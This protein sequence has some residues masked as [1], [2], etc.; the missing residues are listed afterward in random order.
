M[1]VEQPKKKFPAWA[2]A[3][4]VVCVLFFGGLF[5]LRM[6]LHYLFS[7]KSGEYLTQ[8]AAEKTL[9]KM[10]E[11]AGDGK[12]K[13]EV[14][15]GEGGQGI[16]IKSKEGGS[17][18]FAF[19]AGDKMPG[20]FPS[21]I[22][23]FNPAEFKGHV[24]VMGM[25]SLEWESQRPMQEVAQFY[26]NKMVSNGWQSTLNNSGAEGYAGGFKKGDRQVMVK[27]SGEEGRSD[28]NLMYGQIPR[29]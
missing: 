12:E 10:L 1:E 9:E 24:M 25:H 22:A 4:I 15:L 7:T 14:N 11:Q 3:L 21:D 6:G 26:Q 29:N 28:I 13:V 23:I 8:K 16:N 5:A 20:D 17:Q 2:T 19:Q 18:G 27:I